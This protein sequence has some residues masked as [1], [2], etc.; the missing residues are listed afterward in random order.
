MTSNLEQVTVHYSQTNNIHQHQQILVLRLPAAMSI[1]SLQGK[2]IQTSTPTVMGVKG[3]K[4]C[5]HTATDLILLQPS[6]TEAETYRKGTITV[7]LMFSF[8]TWL[9]LVNA[10]N[11]TFLSLSQTP[12]Q[13]TDETTN[14]KHL[15]QQTQQSPKEQNFAKPFLPPGEALQPTVQRKSKKRRK[16]SEASPTPAD[17]KKKRK[18]MKKAKKMP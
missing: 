18:K 15:Q 16:K 1:T 9:F 4:V 8:T 14:L 6:T 3:Y 2:L 11:I 12:Q 7:H 13:S 17:R 5:Q 10:N